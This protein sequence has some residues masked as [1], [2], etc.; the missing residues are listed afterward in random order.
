M[1]L[2]PCPGLFADP[3]PATVVKGLKAFDD[4][5]PAE[6][7]GDKFLKPLPDDRIERRL[8]AGCEEASLF[9][10][11][12]VNFQCKIGHFGTPNKRF[13]PR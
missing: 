4:G 13:R 7:A 8:P 11:S 1:E 3:G 10:E 2:I 12:V 6:V 9:Q 5:L